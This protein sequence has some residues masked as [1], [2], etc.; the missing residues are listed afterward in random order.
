MAE[1][2]YRGGGKPR[3]LP[4]KICGRKPEST[5][6]RSN[7]KALILAAC[8]VWELRNGHRSYGMADRIR[9]NI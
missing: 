4:K 3:A 7:T 8:R 9:A 2:R 5:Y 1:L 6:L